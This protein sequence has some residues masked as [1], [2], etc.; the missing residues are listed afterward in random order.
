MQINPKTT[1]DT[2]VLSIWRDAYTSKAFLAGLPDSVGQVLVPTSKN[3]QDLAKRIAASANVSGTESELKLLA[4][5]NNYLLNLEPVHVPDYVLLLFGC[6]QDNRFPVVIVTREWQDNASEVC[7]VVHSCRDDCV[8]TLQCSP[9][10]VLEL[11]HL[12]WPSS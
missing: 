2:E 11:K 10:S 8:V 6:L 3:I 7:E 12:R 9:N 1:S 5:L 4:S